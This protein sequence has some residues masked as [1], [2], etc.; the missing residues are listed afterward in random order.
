MAL[1]S[2]DAWE[3]ISMAL[4]SIDGR[5]ICMVLSSIDAWEVHMYGSI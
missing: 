3:V 2:I 5:F 4:S 1:S